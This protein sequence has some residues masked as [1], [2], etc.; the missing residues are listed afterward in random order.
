MRHLSRALSAL[1]LAGGLLGTTTGGVLAAHA[2]VR[3]LG[4][5]RCVI[6]AEDGGERHVELPGAVFENNP[7]VVDTVAYP[8]GRRHPLHVLVHIAGAGQGELYVLGS[9]A[10]AAHCVAIVND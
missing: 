7:N 3:A 9:P 4:D 8:D 2:H 10:A 1:A 6:L 5:G